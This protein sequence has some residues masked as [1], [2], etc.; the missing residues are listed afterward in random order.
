MEEGLR[1]DLTDISYYVF[2]ENMKGPTRHRLGKFFKGHGY[3]TIPM[4]AEA[5][6]GLERMISFIFQ[7]IE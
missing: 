6:A 4:H 1:L 5:T 7:V 2:Y 3:D